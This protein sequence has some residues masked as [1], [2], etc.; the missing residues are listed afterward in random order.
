MT[1]FR[2][3]LKKVL[4]LASISRRRYLVI[5]L[6]LGLIG[7]L[8]VAAIAI[9]G[10]IIL[11]FEKPESLPEV[12]VSLGF[13]TVGVL[14]GILG[15][16]YIFKISFA[17]FTQRFLF[18]VVANSQLTLIQRLL[19]QYLKYDYASYS[20]ADPN[21]LVN[22]ITKSIHIYINQCLYPCLRGPSEL[23]TAF[24]IALSLAVV[25][26]YVPLAILV[27]FVIS[28][29]LY[30]SITHKKVANLG[31][32]FNSEQAVM[33]GVCRQ[34]IN[35]YEE[36]T[37]S[38]STDLPLDLLSKSASKY[39]SAGATYYS[40]LII[41]RQFLEALFVL[42][43]GFSILA[44]SR[45]GFDLAEVAMVGGVFAFGALRF[46]PVISNL[47]GYLSDI[48]FSSTSLE[49]LNHELATDM[50]LQE[51]I[52]RT[53]PIEKISGV[54]V[55]FKYDE[56][57]ILSNV[58]FEV[59][60]GK[61]T[62]VIGP[63]GAGKST[64]LRLMLGA[65]SPS[66]GEV[67]VNGSKLKSDRLHGTFIGQ[68]IFILNGTIAQN[69]TMNK[70]DPSL[71]SA[72]LRKALSSAQMMTFTESLKFGVDTSIGD[73]GLTLSGGQKQR[74]ALA[75]AFYADSQIIVLDEPTSSLDKKTASIVWGELIQ[76]SK[77]KIV[78]VVTHDTSLA[79][80]SDAVISL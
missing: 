31:N 4:R 59:Q 3:W 37:A 44:A 74:I 41:P 34:A 39:A 2:D 11:A 53:D 56:A 27:T 75:R 47:I 30:F 68:D 49:K 62:C 54:N 8:D 5:S 9:I 78:V 80:K 19:R 55:S 14:V 38:N 40:L 58:N 18:K 12:M 69:V 15:F 45:L 46:I 36:L 22:N 79:A 71:D 60:L 76:L 42:F 66:D 65:L 28:S 48:R 61:L 77:S 26:P 72:R 6:S 67:R 10:G 21:E 7:I 13:D 70:Y 64:F 57:T 33:L 73:G 35:G 23:I 51:T 17:I 16:T 50:L 24:L 20:K 25:N 43:F 52:Y 29:V 63:S 32:V 1:K